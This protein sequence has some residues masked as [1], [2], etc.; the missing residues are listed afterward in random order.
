MG[1]R[2][3][4]VALV[5]ATQFLGGCTL[6]LVGG[7]AG[8][9]YYVGRDERT[10]GRIIDDASITSSVKAKLVKD[11]RIRALD[12]DVDTHRGIVTLHGHVPSQETSERAVALARSVKGV[13]GVRLD[14]AV[15]PDR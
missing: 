3:L 5:L 2:G 4:T 11:D 1:F 8:G 6:L 13:S 9:G 14:L 7:A 15:V 10:F 12:I